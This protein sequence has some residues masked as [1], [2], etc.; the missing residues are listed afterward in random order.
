[1]RV[2][3]PEKFLWLPARD[4][5]KFPPRHQGETKFMNQITSVD[6]TRDCEA[7]Q[8]PLG[9]VVTLPKGTPVDIT[10]TL[11]GTFTV[12][13]QGGLFRIATKDADALGLESTAGEKPK[14]S[15]APAELDEK[16]VWETLKTCYDPEIPVNIVDLGLVYDMQIDKLPS[17]HNR[18]NVKMTLTAPG[19][20]MGATIAGDAQQ[21]LLY[22]DGVEEANVE[23]VW[24]PAWHQ[25]MIT[26]QGRRILGLE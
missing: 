24:E 13:A 22:L 2:A 25:S 20:G 6:L 21:K 10:Q 19:C 3:D 4:S 18:I 14:T 17:G 5:D 23:I 9:S 1:M 8:I 26:E 11:G 16:Q 15:A 7:V 12:H